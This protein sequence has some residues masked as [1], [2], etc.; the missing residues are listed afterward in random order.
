MSLSPSL[1]KEAQKFIPSGVNS[2]VRAFNGV[3]GSPIFINS[4]DG[5]FVEDVDGKRYL[6]YVCSWGA[7]LVGHNNPV[8]RESVATKIN[9]GL[10]FGAPTTVETK[11]AAT[12]CDLVPSMDQ[13]RMVSSGTEATMSAI[14]LARGYTKRDKIIK[15]EGNYHGHCDSL[16]VKAGSGALTAGVASSL[17]VPEDLAQHTLVANYNDI[18]SVVKFFEEFPQDIAAIIIEPV[19]G[20][21]GCV[22]PQNNFLQKLRAVCDQYQAL[23]ILDEVMTGFRMPLTTAQAY[24]EVKPDLTCLGKVIGGGLPVGAFGG[25]Q[26]VMDCLSPK[27]GVYQAGTLSGNPISM[28]AG[29]AQLELLSYSN[30]FANLF[31]LTEKLATG[32]VGLARDNGIAVQA[33]YLGGMFSI[34]FNEQPVVDY[35]TVIGSDINLFKKFHQAMLEADIYFAPSAFESTF[36]SFAH[37][38]ADIE[39][40]LDAASVIFS[41]KM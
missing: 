6:D 20:N 41:S 8:I 28:T 26:E 19:A 32:L 39:R 23:L 40:T 29:L 21:M 1:I 18:D 3:Y 13:V 35:Q 31:R 12:L 24:Y 14:R 38:D 17:G 7:M 30:K 34:F 16:L 4:A 11:M 22:L 27:G 2:P 33:N 36:L 25:R 37:T 10:S 5:A 15:F 9:S